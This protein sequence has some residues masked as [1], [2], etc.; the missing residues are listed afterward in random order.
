MRTIIKAG[1]LVLL[2]IVSLTQFDSLKQL[3][4]SLERWW[5]KVVNLLITLVTLWLGFKLIGLVSTKLL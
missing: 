5:D 1:L 3:T 2:V 4:T